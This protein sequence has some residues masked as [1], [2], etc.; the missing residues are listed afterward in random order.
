MSRAS[1]ST[2]E[3]VQSAEL[4]LRQREPELLHHKKGKKDLIIPL[5]WNVFILFLLI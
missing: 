1:V 5:I 4:R 2:D 3:Q